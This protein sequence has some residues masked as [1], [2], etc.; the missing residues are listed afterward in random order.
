[1]RK[2]LA[3]TSSLKLGKLTW[4]FHTRQLE[5][6]TRACK[7]FVNG[8]LR[9]CCLV[10]SCSHLYDAFSG[11]FVETES[12]VFCF[13]IILSSALKLSCVFAFAALLDTSIV[14]DFDIKVWNLKTS[15]C[16][17]IR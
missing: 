14:H 9:C 6:V 10:E 15:S 5:T 2:L 17:L 12:K 11:R 1:M 13:S 16:K 8:V 3:S 7:D 4:I